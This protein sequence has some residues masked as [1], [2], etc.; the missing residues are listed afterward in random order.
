MTLLLLTPVGLDRDCWGPTPLTDDQEIRHEFPGFGQRP[1]WQG[2]LTIE[3][4][5]DDVAAHLDAAADVVGVSL[6]GMVAQHLALRHPE[7][8]RSLVLACTGADSNSVAMN[9]RVTALERDGIEAAIEPTLERWFTEDAR[10]ATPPL[11]G[12]E[13]V[14]RTLRALSP[15]AF[16]DGWRVIATHRAAGRLSGVKVP[17]TCLAG[18]RDLAAPPTR[19]RA[20]ASELPSARYVELAGPHLLNLECPD[21]FRT[22]VREH[23]DWAVGR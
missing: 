7:K 15:G 21:E 6:G 22:V 16:A 10:A 11:P 3:S 2:E 18:T 5:A 13:Y 1:R 20:M 12:I 4:W 9:E 14:R 23:L 8:V 19:V 17:V